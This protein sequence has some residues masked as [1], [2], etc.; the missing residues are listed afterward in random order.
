VILVDTSVWIEAFRSAGCAEA[1]ALRALL[2]QDAVSLAA[3][4]RVEILVGASA[5]DQK[6]LRHVLAALPN[7]MPEASTWALIEDWLPLA[8]KAGLRFGMGDLLIAAIAA[9][10][11]APVWSLDR[12]FGRMAELGWIEVSG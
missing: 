6:R 8:A 5:T 12:D 4:I 1:Q 7:W 11:Q 9:E 2:D 10:H 3:P